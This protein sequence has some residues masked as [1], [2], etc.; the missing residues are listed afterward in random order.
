[1]GDGVRTVNPNFR[2][3]DGKALPSEL[4]HDESCDEFR[5]VGVRDLP[6][7]WIDEERIQ[8]RQDVDGKPQRD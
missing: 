5:S 4:G 8:G 6:V 1:M 3:T 2:G 7:D